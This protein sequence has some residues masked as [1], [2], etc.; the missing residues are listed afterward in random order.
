M[1]GVFAEVLDIVEAERVLVPVGVELGE[2]LGLFFAMGRLQSEW[3]STMM[4]ILSPTAFL[5]LRKGSSAVLSSC[6][7]MSQPAVRS[8]AMSNGQIFMPVMPCSS[9]ECARS[10]AR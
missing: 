6:G 5:I 7:L 10:S 3:N 1:A 8:A 9:R 2:A 4:S